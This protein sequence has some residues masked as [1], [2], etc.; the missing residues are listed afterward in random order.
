MSKQKKTRKSTPKLFTFPYFKIPKSSS[1]IKFEHILKQHVSLQIEPIFNTNLNNDQI[2]YF[3]ITTGPNEYLSFPEEYQFIMEIVT[4]C[5]KIKVSDETK[6]VG[7]LDDSFGIY[8]PPSSAALSF[9][10]KITLTYQMRDQ[11]AETSMHWPYP[12][13]FLNIQAATELMFSS[14]SWKN[15]QKT[16]GNTP[17]LNT[18]LYTE[19]LNAYK[20]LA[21]HKL[22]KDENDGP[23][24]TLNGKFL[25]GVLPF[26]PFR[27]NSPNLRNKFQLPGKILLPPFTHIRVGFRKNDLP[28][29]ARM[30]YVGITA[31]TIA[32]NETIT[33]D[34]MKR[35]MEVPPNQFKI[36]KIFTE[37][38]S[39]RLCCEKIMVEPKYDIFRD[40][41]LITYTYSYSRCILYPMSNHS[42][43]EIP[44]RWDTQRL[45]I[46]FEFFFLR[47]H[48]L[49]YELAKNC[50][51]SL[52][53]FYLPNQLQRWELRYQDKSDL[54][55]DN[56]YISDLNENNV[57][58]SK[59]NY[60]NYCKLHQ[61]Y[62]HETQFED[63]FSVDN[64]T[65]ETG[66]Q[67]IYPIDLSARNIQSSLI[68]KGL[69]LFLKFQAPVTTT[70]QKWQLVTKFNY[71]GDLSIRRLQNNLEYI[72]Q[73][74][75][76]S[77]EQV[78][79]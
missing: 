50:P 70:T 61:F 57:N 21:K 29:N 18:I 35:T 33:T 52:N 51:V 19:N 78:K 14:S 73:A 71:I 76:I 43:V 77:N 16:I 72:F 7:L 53:R 28:Q 59:M 15:L 24:T 40:Q 32:S 45:P 68:L 5:E 4:K 75:Q 26:F 3:D 30:E 39:M 47:D 22:H 1:K 8:Y 37:I 60:L 6:S 9:F 67:N 31:K 65:G 44:I 38:K 74:D 10:D 17:S 25:Y 69:T 12:A 42:S 64:T 48:D 62:S 63:V 20:D 56:L 41:K 36:D 27:L 58:Q 54:L 34:G 23:P 49:N 11:T 79:I 46:T 66:Y 13:Q 55:Y 2:I